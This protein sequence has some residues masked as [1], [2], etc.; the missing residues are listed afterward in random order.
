MSRGSASVSS[1]GEA[2]ASHNLVVVDRVSAAAD[3]DDELPGARDRCIEQVALEHRVVVLGEYRFDHC[4]EFG[5]LR[6]V[7][8]DSERVHRTSWDIS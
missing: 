4:G 2:G 7:D 8:A 5:F 6:L 3:K 1:A